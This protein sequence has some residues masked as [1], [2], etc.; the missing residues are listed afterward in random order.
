MVLPG[1][2][3]NGMIV[4]DD[5]LALPEGTAVQVAVVVPSSAAGKGRTLYD[6]L[7]PLVGQVPDLPS[8][9]S[10]NLDHYLYDHPKS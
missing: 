5:P 10:Q 4:L 7:Q 3:R 2:V 6:V 8:D 1:Q 9:G